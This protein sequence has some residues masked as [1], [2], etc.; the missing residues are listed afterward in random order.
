MS[1]SIY[2]IFHDTLDPRNYEQLT[3]EEFSLL[4]FVCVNKE[5]PKTYDKERFT[6]ILYEWDLPVYDPNLQ[7]KHVCDNTM[8]PKS[9]FN[10][11]GVHWHLATNRVCQTEYI[12]ICHN[13]MIFTKGSVTRVIE[14]LAPGRGVT[15]ARATYDQLILTSTFGPTEEPMYTYACKKLGANKDTPRYYPMFTNCAMETEKFYAA[16]PALFQVNKDLFMQ[17]LPGPWYRPAITYERTWALAMGNVL[18]EVVVVTGILHSH[19]PI[20]PVLEQTRNGELH[21]YPEYSR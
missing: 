2:V 13:D 5:I 19:P 9:H 1:L 11:T 12:Y 16:M 4:T 14:S 8:V 10:E 6:N 15:I 21:Q 3:P 18:D 7:R 17:T 20:E